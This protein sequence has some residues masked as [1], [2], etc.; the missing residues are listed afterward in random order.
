MYDSDEAATHKTNISGWVTGGGLYYGKDEHIARWAGCTHIRCECGRIREKSY[1]ICE[2]CRRK[3]SNERYAA[4]PFVEWDGVTPLTLWDDDQ[5][6]F[7]E[8]DIAEYC[9]DNEIKSA[10]LLLVICDPVYLSP[11]H[12]DYWSDS[13]PEEGELPPAIQKLVKELNDAIKKEGPACWKQGKKRTAVEIN[14]GD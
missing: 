5:Y 11:L 1:T 13:L 9:E 4:L 14:D 2:D 6:F 12:E 7:G 8:D 3:K 10:D